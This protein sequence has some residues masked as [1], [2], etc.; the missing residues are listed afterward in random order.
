MIALVIATEETLMPVSAVPRTPYP[1]ERGWE[2][3][4]VVQAREGVGRRGHNH[5]QRFKGGREVT[6]NQANVLT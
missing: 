2:A 6:L 3:V 5:L 4:E 1:Q